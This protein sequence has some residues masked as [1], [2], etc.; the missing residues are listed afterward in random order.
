MFSLVLGS[1]NAKKLD[2]LRGLLPAEAIELHSLA[3]TAGAVEVAETGTTFRENAALKATEQAQHLGRWVLAE[4]SGISVDALDGRPGVYSARF[5]GLHSDDRANNDRLLQELAGIPEAKRT[6]HYTCQLCLADP[7]GNIR[8]EGTGTCHGRI[9]FAPQGDSGFG[10]D[11]LFIIHEYHQTFGQL[12][13]VVKRVLSH[14]ARALRGFVPRL[15]HL[16]HDY[17]A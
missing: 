11:P 7:E 3:E 10:Y 14:R 17:S 13:P 5:A 9:G 15:L 2:E 4:D 8:L 6:A 16:I 12:G 1:H